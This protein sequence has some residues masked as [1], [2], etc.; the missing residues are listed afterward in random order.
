MA[1]KERPLVKMKYR[2]LFTLFFVLSA[3]FLFNIRKMK[4]QK[5]NEQTNV[6]TQQVLDNSKLSTE[7]SAD[8]N[9]KD[10]DQE[11]SN[12]LG[13]FNELRKYCLLKYPEQ[14]H[15]LPT[16]EQ[17]NQWREDLS[18]KRSWLN[19][20]LKTQDNTVMRV[21]RFLDEGPNGSF[22]RLVVFQEDETGFPEII[23]IPQEHQLSPSE[24]VIQKYLSLGER[25]FED[26][27]LIG[28]IEGKNIFIE[29]MNN[30]VTRVDVSSGD[31]LL[32]CQ[33]E[34]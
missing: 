31:Q 6:Q 26:E 8:Q 33:S 14:A 19:V 30:Q 10:K 29:L 9:P 1:P 27:G 5:M 3:L 2:V 4:A 34:Y 22:E 24:D 20:H 17:I 23:D 25:I 16:Q 11:S 18:L 21:R 7:V 15:L 13:T 32:N 12:S 28:E